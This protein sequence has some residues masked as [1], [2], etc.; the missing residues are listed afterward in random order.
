MLFFWIY[1]HF[2]GS[3]LIEDKNSIQFPKIEDCKAK[4]VEIYKYIDKK[5]NIKNK[6]SSNKKIK[7]KNK[8]I[9]IIK[10]NYKKENIYLINNAKSNKLKYSLSSE[11]ILGYN[12]N[13][14]NKFRKEGNI[15]DV[16][17]KPNIL[18]INE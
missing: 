4:Q 12:K 1:Y 18:N 6:N 14:N 8:S 5:N 13:L 15:L 16:N 9:S 2:Y 17:I 3:F 10:S 11:N 7:N